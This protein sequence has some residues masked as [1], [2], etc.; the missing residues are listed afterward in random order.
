MYFGFFTIN[1]LISK[2]GAPNKART[3]NK[4]RLADSGCY[5]LNC[6]MTLVKVVLSFVSTVHLFPSFYHFMEAI[7]SRLIFF[8]SHSAPNE[9]N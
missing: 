8:L 9:E 2:V 3:P 7:E 6:K 1:L 5:A 4:A